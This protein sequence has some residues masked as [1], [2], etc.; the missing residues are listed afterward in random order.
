MYKKTTV[1]LVSQIS[2]TN[3]LTVSIASYKMKLG[4]MPHEHVS[5]A[6]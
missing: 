3:I 2:Y 5:A 6:Q 4:V 1:A